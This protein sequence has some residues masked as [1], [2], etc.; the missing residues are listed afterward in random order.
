MSSPS[1]LRSLPFTK[2]HGAGNDFVVFDALRS[3]L[4]ADLDC[5]MT[6]VAEGGNTVP[7]LRRLEGLLATLHAVDKVALVALGAKGPGFG[8]PLKDAILPKVMVSLPPAIGRHE[9]AGRSAVFI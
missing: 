3:E 9:R 5:D 8:L 1:L 7:H 2:M 4:P 6:Q